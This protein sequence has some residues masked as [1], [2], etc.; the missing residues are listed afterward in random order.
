MINRDDRQRIF[1][2]KKQKN[3]KMYQKIQRVVSVKISGFAS[4]FF[5]TYYKILFRFRTYDGFTF[6]KIKHVTP[7]S[8]NNVTSSYIF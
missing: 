6:L 3:M 7:G 1:D 8:L 4:F 5:Q 2:Y